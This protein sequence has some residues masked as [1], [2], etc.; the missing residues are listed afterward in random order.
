MDKNKSRNATPGGQSSFSG[1]AVAVIGTT[2][3]MAGLLSFVIFPAAQSYEDGLDVFSALCRA[4]GLEQEAPTQ[5]TG[6][7]RGSTV[8][9]DS[10]TLGLLA[11]GD[12]ARGRAYAADVCVSCHLPN[13]LVSDPKIT[14][15]ITGQSARA[16]YKQ[17][18]DIK[19]GV[20]I[21]DV[22]K[23][24]ADVLDD[25][26]MSDVAAYYSSLRPRNQ[27]NLASIPV[28]QK[29][30]D[31]VLRGDT[32]RALP[33]CTSCHERR[34]GGPLEAPNLT[35]QYRPYFETQMNAFASGVRR[36]DLYSR[37]RVIAK[38]LTPQEIDELSAYYNAPPLPAF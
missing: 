17:L 28:S 32:A 25:Q 7:T 1:K 15:A 30:L 19:A 29:T 27:D 24:I 38:R 22:M 23:P 6:Q 16:I 9:F 35:G 14:P 4:L 12:I 21:S 10:N 37:M 18:K 31:L 13:S 5:V 8:A 20:R 3:I 2:A 11:G 26:Q 34:T 36:N 33:A